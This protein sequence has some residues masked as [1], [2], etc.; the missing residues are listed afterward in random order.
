MKKVTI[1]LLTFALL[2]SC[3]SKKKYVAL[4]QENG[5]IRSQLQKTEVEK[6]ELEA[7]FAKIQSRVDEYNSKIN[8]LTEE[9]NSKMVAVD[10][11]AVIS[12]DAREQMRETLKNVDPAIV[13]QATSLKDSMNIAVSY[14][15]QKSLDN[16][17]LNEDEDIAIDIDETVV[18]I[19]ISDKMLFNSGSYRVSNKANA[20]L[21]KIADIINS[22]E[23]LDLMVEGHTDNK[24]LLESAG[25]RDNWD[26]SVLRATSVVRKLQND[27]DV[28]PEKL[29]AS[30][31]SFY[32]PLVSND[33]KENRAKNR[34]TRIVIL[35]NI[36]KFFALMAS[37]Q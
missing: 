7:K 37:N 5:E 4:E 35:P 21:Q 25:I 30:G 14:N 9:N 18:M 23:S 34:R 12:N 2:T 1:T 29:I 20:I 32:Q 28:A 24:L 26:L 22:E 31:R 3:V 19:S 16:S 17:T 36:D 27:Y 8:S 6:E 13:S 10:D 15:L 33:T 11:V